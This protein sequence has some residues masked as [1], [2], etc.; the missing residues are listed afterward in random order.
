MNWRLIFLALGVILV[1]T[2]VFLPRDWYDEL[3]RAAA[4]L[5]WVWHDQSTES[6]QNQPPQPIRGVT[7]LQISLVIEG[8]VFLWIGLKWRRAVR[9]DSGD[10]LPITTAGNETNSSLYF[11]LA[12]TVFGSILRLIGLNADF[13]LD[14]IVSV[15][16]YTQMPAFQV[17]T[18]YI[19]S[20]NHLLNTL[21]MKLSVSLFGDQ[22]WAFRLPAVIFGTA[23]IPIFYWVS[24]LVFSPRAGLSAALLLAV[25]YH[26][27]FFSQNARGYTAYLFFS[28]LASGL[29]VRG[30]Q[31]DRLLIWLFYI[32]AMFLSFASLLNTG[33]VF[34]SHILIGAAAL[35]VIKRRRASPFPLMRRLITVFGAT[36]FLV[37]QLY[38][39]I[40]PQV[41]VYAQ[42]TYSDPASGFSPFSVDFWVEMVRGISAGFG[43]NLIWLMLPLA[44]IPV[45]G[46]AVLLRRQWVLMAALALPGILTAT[47]LLLNRLTFSPR[48]FLL[49]LPLAILVAVQG[50][51]SVA[52]FLV[53]KIRANPS[54]WS[55][56][57]AAAVVL[58]GCFVSLA[59][60]KRYYSIPKQAYRASLDFIVAE[61][62][63]D[64]III[65][66]HLAE[67]GYRYYAPRF[68]LEE[69][70]DFFSVRSIETL[71]SV[72]SRHADQN[73]FLVTTFPR[74]LRLTHP[75]LAERIT[76][77]F[78][79]V[80]TFPATIGDGEVSVWKYRQNGLN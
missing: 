69:G 64:E 41:Y 36:T 79:S 71:D 20:N 29:L 4:D 13:W 1:L 31:E 39:T 52:R 10:R 54:V 51:E 80:R 72:L 44:A 47:F 61:R 28:I 58:L 32:A 46:F 33:F 7:L 57:L 2:G 68:N 55:P 5:P 18:S 78:E 15:L 11:L 23:T 3:P 56:K 37:F 48:F 24:R 25:S 65:V 40:L 63:S 60:L 66:I 9:I 49:A 26:H 45:I 53:E 73:I 42:T 74:A 17:V 16:L 8:L 22:E 6:A 19:N 21:L 30:L 62:K 27:I 67:I 38:A 76:R 43:T 75:D 70:K 59:S 77:D 14:E 12:I 35:F 50:I 34:A